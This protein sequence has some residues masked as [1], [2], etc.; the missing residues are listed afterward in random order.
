MY[1]VFKTFHPQC[2]V[3][4]NTYINSLV[5]GIESDLSHLI[6]INEEI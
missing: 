1:F 2:T 6:L 5:E 3:I 4:Q